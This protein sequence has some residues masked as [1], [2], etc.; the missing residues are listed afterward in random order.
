MC[1]I[2]AKLKMR[3][4][5]LLILLGIIRKIKKI[6]FVGRNVN[7]DFEIDT[8]TSDNIWMRK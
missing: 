2:F 1:E 4:E 3:K 8:E 5:N 7:N 6:V